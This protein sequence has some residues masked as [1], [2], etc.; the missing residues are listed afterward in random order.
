VF[1][2]SF[3]LEKIMRSGLSYIIIL[4]SMLGSSTAQAERLLVPDYVSCDR[5]NLTSWTGQVVAYTHHDLKTVITLDTD[6]GTTE[7]LTLEPSQT[8]ALT[9]QYYVHG[10]HF[11]LADWAKIENEDRHL[12]PNIRATVWLCS[13]ASILPIINWLPPR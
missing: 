13:E 3:F 4:M 2:T 7:T 10:K 5:N 8:A 11:E 9:A 1:N 6:D 12:L